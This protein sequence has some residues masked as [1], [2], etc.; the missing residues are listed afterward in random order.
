M[1]SEGSKR[2]EHGKVETEALEAD[3]GGR[4]ASR[5]ISLRVNYEYTMVRAQQT[6]TSLSLCNNYPRMSESGH[7]WSCPLTSTHAHHGLH[8]HALSCTH[9]HTVI[10]IRPTVPLTMNQGRGQ[11]SEFSRINI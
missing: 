3:T 4:G 9:K 7:N 5:V 2:G 10:K 11:E 1:G 8:T 6:K